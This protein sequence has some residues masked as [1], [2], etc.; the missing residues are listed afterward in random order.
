MDH[1]LVLKR[2]RDIAWYQF[3]ACIVIYHATALNKDHVKVKSSHTTTQTKTGNKRRRAQ[4]PDTAETYRRGA[5]ARTHRPSATT[6]PFT[7][8]HVETRFL[9]CRAR[10]R[11]RRRWPVLLRNASSGRG[12]ICTRGRRCTSYVP[13]AVAQLTPISSFFSS[14]LLRPYLFCSLRRHTGRLG[15]HRACTRGVPLP[16][17]LRLIVCYVYPSR[18]LMICL[19]TD[20]IAR[21]TRNFLVCADVHLDGI[22]PTKQG[23]IIEFSREFHQAC[24]GRYSSLI[25]IRRLEKS[26]V[27]YILWFPA[28]FFLAKD[29]TLIP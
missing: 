4:D 18:P 27:E 17:Y 8:L 20:E 14:C 5:V 13:C 10:T 16:C 22:I 3:S 21:R 19:L 6:A 24:P 11:R 15:L 7:H 9:R 29:G 26:R 23:K 1:N 12:S 2:Y 28:V 25:L